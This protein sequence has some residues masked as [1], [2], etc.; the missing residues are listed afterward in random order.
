MTSKSPWASLVAQLVKNPP[1]MQKTKVQSLDWE[2]PLEE[3]MAY[4]LLYSGL[5]ISMDS[6]VCGVAKSWM[7]LSD[8]H[9]RTHKS[10]SRGMHSFI[11]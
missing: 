4:P 6:I 9:I 8:F 3:G 7:W 5:E 2:D 10:Q 11:Q 1:V